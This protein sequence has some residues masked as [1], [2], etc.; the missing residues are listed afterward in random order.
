M[1]S[2]TRREQVAQIFGKSVY[3][4]ADVAL[5]PLSSQRDTEKAITEALS[6]L[7]KS[8]QSVKSDGESSDSEPS[9][10]ESDEEKILEEAPEVSSPAEDARPGVER[11]SS[12]TNI[13]E[14]VFTRR[15]PYGRFASQ[16]FSKRGWALSQ[17]ISSENGGHPPLVSTPKDVEDG[18]RS[19]EEQPK[20]HATLTTV[21]T[22]AAGS[23]GPSQGETVNPD[24]TSE[25]IHGLL[26]KLLRSTKLI[27]SS[28]S[29]FFSYDLDLTRRLGESSLPH[30][31]PP[32]ME[33]IDPLVC[34]LSFPPIQ[35]H[36]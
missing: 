24:S 36:V 21:S 28:R 32:M 30:L 10:S 1:I 15:G 22:S 16:W 9:A 14:E 19:T 7:R 2:V 4:V 11:S 13:A 33:K 29:F 35:V 18:L 8:D 6:A 17:P 27:L 31:K 3:V 34:R 26:P 25:S 12:S 20:E 5:L 23:C